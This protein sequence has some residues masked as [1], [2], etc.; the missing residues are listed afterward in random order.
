[1]IYNLNLGRL[2]REIKNLKEFWDSSKSNLNLNVS[3]NRTKKLKVWKKNLKRE[4][5]KKGKLSNADM[6]SNRNSH[7][8]KSPLAVNSRMLYYEKIKFYKFFIH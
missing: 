7:V 2:I 5:V 4:E 8:F 6:V 1:M 3:Y